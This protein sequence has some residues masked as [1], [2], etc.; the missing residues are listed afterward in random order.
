MT[1]STFVPNLLIQKARLERNLTSGA[2][3]LHMVMS[4]TPSGASYYKPLNFSPVI[5][6]VAPGEYHPPE[7]FIQLNEQSAQAMLDALWEAGI[8]PSSGQQQG[9]NSDL[10]V[11]LMKD[12]LADLRRIVFGQQIEVSSDTPRTV[13]SIPDHM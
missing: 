13:I 4:S 3:D 10:V 2:Y 6:H 11:A 9:A 12:H 5:Q 1:S 8:R 7:P